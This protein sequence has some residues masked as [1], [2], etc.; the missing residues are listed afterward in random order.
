MTL[1]DLAIIVAFLG[2][3]EL[4]IRAANRFAA[5]LYRDLER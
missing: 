3:V 4:W 5:W 1:T 2:F